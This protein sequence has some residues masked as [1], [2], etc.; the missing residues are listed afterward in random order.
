MSEN[1]KYRVLVTGATGNQGGAVVDALLV[2]GHQ[3]LAVTRNTDSP[4]AK[5]LINRG[6]EVLQGNMNDDDSMRRAL[7]G[8]DTFY[9]MGSPFE[10]GVDA[11]TAQGIRLVDLAKEAG[12]GHLVYGSVASANQDTRIPHFDSKYKVEQHLAASGLDYSISAP[13]YFM[14]NLIAPWSTDAL[15]TGQIMMAMPEDV[16]LQQVSVKNIGDFVTSLIERREGVFGQRYDIAGD[17]LDG[18]TLAVQ[19]SKAIGHTVNYQALPA[20]ALKQQDAD[21]GRM[22]EWFTVT[23]Y[24]VDIAGLRETFD[25]VPWQSYS[26]WLNSLDLGV[27]QRE[28]AIA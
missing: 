12:I 28:A 16:N 7:E 3:V 25:D 8:I 26:Q 9:L 5:A 19:V 13:V 23:G 11:E 20:D 6:V 18:V 22:F 27:Y 24:D 4:R 10:D 15:K 1:K 14:D 2:K 21:M 17:E